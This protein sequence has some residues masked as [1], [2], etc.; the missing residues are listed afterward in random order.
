[1][2]VRANVR[3]FKIMCTPIKVGICTL[4]DVRQLSNP[5]Y[6]MNINKLESEQYTF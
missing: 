2:S 1:M 3:M 4:H 5:V 6:P